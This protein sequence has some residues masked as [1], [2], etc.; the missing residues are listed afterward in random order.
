MTTTIREGQYAPGQ[1]THDLVVVPFHHPQGCRSYLAVDPDSRRA[2]AIDPHLDLVDKLEE[3]VRRE[4][5]TVAF[6][7]DTHT[8]A[9]HPSGSAELAARL[10]SVRVAHELARH[11]GVALHPSDGQELPLGRQ[12]ARV[13]HAPGHTPDH[14]V[15]ELGG[16]LFSGDTLL[17]GAVARTDFLGGDAGQLYD[18]LQRLIR[19]LPAETVLYPG[20][21]Y[22]G[23]TRSSLADEQRS[24]PW[25][26][27]RER[28]AFA[29][30]L[31]RGAPPRP[32]N[33][34]DLLRLNREGTPI[35]TTVPAV[36]LVARLGGGGA[37][38]V[39]DVR[40]GAEYESEHVDGSRWVPLG[41]LVERADEIRAVPAPRMLLCRTGARASV[42]RRELEALG[43]SGLTVIEGGLEALRTAGL[44]TVRG[45]ARMSLERQVR[46]AAGSLVLAGVALG[47]LVHPAL[48]GLSGA[49]G[50]GLV[51]AGVTDW[52]GM[53]LL[54]ARMPWNKARGPLSQI[55]SGG[56]AAAPAAGGCSASAPRD[57]QLPQ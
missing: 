48:F 16:A 17:I 39:I 20:H 47:A 45:R 4:G 40:T 49:V 19:L 10:A 25:L 27:I 37:A 57:P 9:D 18:T 41:E 26:A 22:E 8:H 12:R 52:C 5:W 53:G 11:R 54:L 32:A 28:E 21:D 50:A 15:V 34:D 36:E 51:F 31:S 3:R 42:A 2:I 13:F 43:I 44:A 35:P 24:N 46:I 33:M 6:V 38:S 30:E 55:P 29:R 1:A 7:L 56:C 14:L 23:R